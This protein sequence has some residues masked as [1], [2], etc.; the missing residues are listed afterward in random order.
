MNSADSE[1]TERNP[2]TEGKNCDIIIANRIDNNLK[3]LEGKIY[4]RDIFN[5]D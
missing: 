1:K 4:T 2:L 3:G 5:I